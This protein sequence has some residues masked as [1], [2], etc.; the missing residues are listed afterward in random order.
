MAP[1]GSHG[2]VAPTEPLSHQGA[3]VQELGLFGAHLLAGQIWIPG[4][5]HVWLWAKQELKSLLTLSPHPLST[6]C[7]FLPEIPA[8]EF[9]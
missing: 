7:V 2:P 6:Q 8:L 5:G 4:E 1:I 3:S 9:D